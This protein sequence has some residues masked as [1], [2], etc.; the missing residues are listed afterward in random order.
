MTAL[1]PDIH[2]KA[3]SVLIRLLL[4][5]PPWPKLEKESL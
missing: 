1:F 5:A 2:P 4:E 3:E